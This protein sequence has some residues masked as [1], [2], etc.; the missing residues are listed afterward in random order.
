MAGENFNSEA[1]V[2]E[3]IDLAIVFIVD[4]HCHCIGADVLVLNRLHRYHV[5]VCGR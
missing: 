4:L 2:F 5:R 3:H 1:L